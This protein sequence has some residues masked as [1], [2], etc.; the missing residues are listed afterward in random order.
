ME[1]AD[2]DRALAEELRQRQMQEDVQVVQP[3]NLAATFDLD[4]AEGPLQA[5]FTN[6]SD[7]SVPLASASATVLLVEIR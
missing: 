2:G 6:V 4:A 3:S 5:L 7:W 1:A